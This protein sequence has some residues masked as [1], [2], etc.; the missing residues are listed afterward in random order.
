M[1]NTKPFLDQRHWLSDHHIIVLMHLELAAQPHI[2]DT[3]Y[4]QERLRA[5]F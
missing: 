2:E 1:P 5:P 4:A 3:Y